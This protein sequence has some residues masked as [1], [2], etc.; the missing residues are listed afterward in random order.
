MVLEASI[1]VSPSS[2]PTEDAL[3]CLLFTLGAPNMVL[4]AEETVRLCWRNARLRA[5]AH[6]S[7][8]ALSAPLPGH[9]LKNVG[10]AWL[11]SAATPWGGLP[12]GVQ[13]EGVIPLCSKMPCISLN[14]S[15]GYAVFYTFPSL[16][17]LRATSSAATGLRTSVLGSKSLRLE[18]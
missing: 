9:C 15:V 16:P 11:S 18:C 5:F 7:P 1:L 4:G 13:Q 14:C 6:V 3:F 17:R 10:L 12:S 2:C 8:T